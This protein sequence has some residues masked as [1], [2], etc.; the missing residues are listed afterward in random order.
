LGLES[1]AIPLVL[2]DVETADQAEAHQEAH[3]TANQA[4]GAV[5]LGLE[6][7]REHEYDGQG[8]GAA[9]V[10]EANHETLHDELGPGLGVEE[11]DLARPGIGVVPAH[12][13]KIYRSAA[14]LGKNI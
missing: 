11:V 14:V 7:R 2:H 1:T 10:E 9:E 13:E 12:G 6:V 5:L 8:G 4:H 3:D